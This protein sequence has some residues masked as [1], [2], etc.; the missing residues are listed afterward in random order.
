M[1]LLI[2]QSNYKRDSIFFAAWSSIA[3]SASK[4][5]NDR[6]KHDFTEKKHSYS[7]T[8]FYYQKFCRIVSWVQLPAMSFEPQISNSQPLPLQH[9]HWPKII[10]M[11]A[12]EFL[13]QKADH[14]RR[15]SD[16][17]CKLDICC[18]TIVAPFF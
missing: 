7:V 18:L 1:N 15:D 16:K 12:N 4:I 11:I 5:R 13:V 8:L 17:K 6:G 10:S 2:L 14:R 9:S 3:I